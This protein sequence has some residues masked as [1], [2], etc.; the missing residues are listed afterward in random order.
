MTAISIIVPIYNV[1]NYLP[2][3]IDSLRRQSFSD[4]EIVG[5]VDGGTDRS[6]LFAK[7]YEK[8]EPRMRVI[9]KENGGLSSARNVGI[10]AATGTYLMFVDSDDMLTPDACKT[11]FDIFQKTGA[12]AVTF[13]AWCYPRFKTTPWHEK[14]LQPNDVFYESFTPDIL[15]KEESHPFA[16][17]TAVKRELL[18]RTGLR[19]DETVRYGEDQ[20]FHFALY[21]KAKG[22][23]LSPKRLY[24]YRL[25]RT[26][27]LTAVSMQDEF[28]RLSEHIS[29][30]ERICSNWKDDGLMEQHGAELAEWVADFLLPYCLRRPASDRGILVPRLRNLFKTYFSPAIIERISSSN[31]A[32]LVC[33]DLI[34]PNRQDDVNEHLR[35]SFLKAY[36]SHGYAQH[37]S[38]AAGEDRSALMS[39][40]R[41]VLPMSAVGLETRLDILKDRVEQ[42]NRE[43]IEREDK[44]RE[45]NA[46]YVTWIVEE[47]GACARSLAQ[48]R[49]ELIAKGIQIDNALF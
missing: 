31:P 39:K 30:C 9:V 43:Q 48:L 17:R 10:E 2:Q 47:T 13:G 15:F 34:N 8:V 7:L 36:N 46:M 6:E 20:V 12:E 22:V 5:V 38:A 19:F 27:S 42:L 40:M 18:M 11:V 23:A 44:E 29:I 49:L 41:T 33:L 4:I 1:E 35:T 16:C 21:P 28:P 37:E 26:D 24:E 25:S 14:N 3:C 45:L 32:K